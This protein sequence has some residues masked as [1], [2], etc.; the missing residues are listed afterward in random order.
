M[1]RQVEFLSPEGKYYLM[2]IPDDAPDD[3]AR[4]GALIGPPDLTEL[5]LP[6]EVEIRLHNQLYW[7]KI[8]T[9]R[10]LRAKRVDAQGAVQAALRLDV[11]RILQV[12]ENGDF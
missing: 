6:T 8:F 9:A 11:D 3:M 4:F 7:R 12:M 2:A 10:D 1:S 5:D